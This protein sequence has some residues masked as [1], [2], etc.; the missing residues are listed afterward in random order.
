MVKAEK[1]YNFFDWW[2]KAF[3]E[4]YINFSGRARRSEYWYYVLGNFI[5]IVPLYIVFIIAIVTGSEALIGISGFL[6]VAFALATIIPS[7]AVAVR[8][9]HDTNKSGW[10]YLLALIP[11]IGS[12]IILYYFVLDGDHGRNDYGNDPKM[13]QN[14]EIDFIGRE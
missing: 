3:I 14:N 10:T 7:F 9:L 6:L 4:N 12:M 5:I 8:R 13:A 11:F 2:K 1:D